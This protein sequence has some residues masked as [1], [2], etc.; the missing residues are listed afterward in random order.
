M[1]LFCC[2]LNWSVYDE[3]FPY[4]VASAAQDWAHIDPDEYYDWHLDFGNNIVF[5]QS[6]TWS[7]YAF[8][9][10]KLGPLAPQKGAQLLPR[11][12]ERAKKDKLPFMGYFYLATDLMFSNLYKEWTIPNSWISKYGLC[13]APEGPWGELI[14]ARINEYMRMYPETD[15]ILFDGFA[16]GWSN[17]CPV[18]PEWF[19][20]KPF[21]EIIGRN[22]PEK[23]EEI[24]PEESRKYKREILSRF[25]YR[26]KEAVNSVNPNTKLLFNC[27][28]YWESENPL[29]ADHPVLHESD[30]LYA[31]CSRDDVMNWLLEQKRPEQRVV[32]TI[33]GRTSDLE[34]VIDKSLTDPEQWKKWYEKGCDFFGY[35]W[36][37][38]PDFRPH[39]KYAEQ[40][41]VVRQ[42]F[43]AM[44]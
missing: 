12:Y 14:C 1:K 40:L 22:M 11:L 31:E 4:T 21:K 23:A 5:C 39:R 2:D 8:Y 41:E 16:Y 29:L 9:P 19:V 17:D 43:H 15:W 13:L 44:P 28:S 18:Q 6:Y 33:I 42:A 10:S 26:V 7:G 35:A 32:T 36:G 38:P 3:P 24:D 37:T 25:F 30:A 34:T 27:A 20:K